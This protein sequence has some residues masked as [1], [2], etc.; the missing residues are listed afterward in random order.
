MWNRFFL[1]FGPNPDAE[2]KNRVVALAKLKEFRDEVARILRHFQVDVDAEQA[3]AEHPECLIFP[4]LGS[5]SLG[6]VGEVVVIAMD[7]VNHRRTRLASLR[8]RVDERQN[9]GKGHF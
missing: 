9:R 1:V 7:I 4:Q 5:L 2:K 6:Q 8:R 3:Q